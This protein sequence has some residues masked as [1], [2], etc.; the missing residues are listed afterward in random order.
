MGSWS[1][2]GSCSGQ[3]IVEYV[4]ATTVVMVALAAIGGMWADWHTRGPAAVPTSVPAPYTPS[5]VGR[6]TTW[7]SDILAH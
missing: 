5:D 1:A 3:S 7:Q 2:G 6:E 4:I